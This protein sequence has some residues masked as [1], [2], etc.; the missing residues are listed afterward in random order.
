MSQLSNQIKDED[1][2][3]NG[4]TKHLLEK[5]LKILPKAHCLDP[6]PENNAPI[7]CMEASPCYVSYKP[8][9]DS[10]AQNLC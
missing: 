3:P 7:I 8:P 2:E 1:V 9:L 10:V 4:D 6:V 5:R